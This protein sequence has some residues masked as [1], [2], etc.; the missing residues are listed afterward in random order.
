MFVPA[1][2]TSCYVGLGGGLLIFF[3]G[4]CLIKCCCVVK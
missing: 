3:V 2:E 1:D 4:T